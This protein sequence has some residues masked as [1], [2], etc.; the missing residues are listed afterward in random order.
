MVGVLP[1]HWK[2]IQYVQERRD[3]DALH[4]VMKRLEQMLEGKE[5]GEERSCSGRANRK[6]H[7]A[8]SRRKVMLDADLADLYGVST[9]RLNEAVKRN[10]D[11]FPVDFMFQL[12][13]DEVA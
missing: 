11:R 7:P 8:H 13:D 10:I 9:K 6:V 5:H 12:T 2:K 3:D 1:Y 4:E